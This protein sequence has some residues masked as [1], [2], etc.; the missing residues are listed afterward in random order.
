MLTIEE[1]EQISNAY[2]KIYKKIEVEYLDLIAIQLKEIGTLN[3]VELSRLDQMALMNKNVDIINKELA[4]RTN[5]S[6]DELKT[7]LT[8]IAKMQYTDASRFY[9]AAGVKQ[10]DFYDNMAVQNIITSISNLTGSTMQNI[11]STS[12]SSQA[13]ISAVDEA[14]IASTS[15]VADYNTST[16]K[17]I[18]NLVSKG[19][20]QVQYPSGINRN[21][22]SA[23]RMNVMDG[24]HQVNMNVASQIGNEFGA[25]GVQI[26]SH[27]NPAPDHTS[28]DGIM[29]SNEN[30]ERINSNLSRKIATCNCY[31]FAQPVL[32]GISTPMYTNAELREKKVQ[33]SQLI[34]YN[35]SAKT[36]YEWSQEQ[37]K[38][39]SRM[40]Y[41]KNENRMAKTMGNTDLELESRNKYKILSSNY[42]KMSASV[43][44]DTE[45]DR[46]Y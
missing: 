4:V 24:M 43:G 36:R 10:L 41:Y 19:M 26:T 28:I 22:A 34:E 16:K 32:M 3:S 12:I 35:N 18:R 13:Y 31:H 14:I 8:N 44:L 38:I 45:L 20:T 39:E 9:T 27:A 33:E 11:S 42:K 5:Q 21:V 30:F 7:T 15:G 46:L 1:Q 37:R 17:I 2:Y 25:D 6:V 23:V 29:V 40:Q